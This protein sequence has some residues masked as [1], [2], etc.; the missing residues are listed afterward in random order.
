MVD[1]LLN[2]LFFYPLTLVSRT[3]THSFW[4]VY[5]FISCTIHQYQGTSPCTTMKQFLPAACILFFLPLTGSA[6]NLVANGSFEDANLCTEFHKYCAPEAWVATSGEANYYYGDKKAY[7]GFHYIGLTAGSLT[8]KGARNFIRTRLLCGLR[9]GHQYHIEF[10][11]CA[12]YKVLD[13]IGV[14]FSSQDYLY[15]QKSF[16]D[17]QPVY[18]YT[19]GNATADPRVWQKVHFVYTAT[20]E[21]AFLV[22]G[23]YKRTDY[24][25]ITKPDSQ[26]EYLLWLDKVSVLPADANEKICADATR[27]QSELYGDDDRHHLLQKRLSYYIQH[28]P[29]PRPKLA[30]TRV[31]AVQHIDTL[32]IPDIYF[33]SASADLSQKSYV[34]L[35]SFAIKLTGQMD[36]IIVNGHTDSI[37]NLEYNKELSL[38][39]AVSVK[40]YLMSKLPAIGVSYIARGYAYL[41]PVATNRTASGRKKNRRVEIYVYRKD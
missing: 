19:R 6:Q 23:L 12:S 36:S 30:L 25:G 5:C 39:R 22:I 40:Q 16:R 15:N 29:A 38:T 35:D 32:I 2:L 3:S 20:G 37:G 4:N 27:Q 18:W 28:P 1:K 13:S 33:V 26:D 17:I 21:E 34:L 41:Q 10:Y 31:P 9:K 8:Q 11:V 24:T 7:D 14:Y